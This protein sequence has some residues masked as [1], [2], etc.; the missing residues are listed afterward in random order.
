MKWNFLVCLL[1]PLALFS[2]TPFPALP[3]VFQDDLIPRMDIN[4]PPDSLA[5]MLVPGSEY[6]WHASFIFNNGQIK[7][8]LE[9]VGVKIRGNTSVGAAKKSFRV[10]FN[11]Y[12]PGRKWYDLE[13]LNLN[14]SHNDPV[15]A[16]AKISWDLL[17]WM[18]I[19]RPEIQPRKTLRQR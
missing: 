6:H 12:E 3:P 8:T 11:T 15:V 4:L 9:N 17:R 1:L 13:K 14:G 5:L 7:D 2:Q 10:S 18:G 19:P 16:R